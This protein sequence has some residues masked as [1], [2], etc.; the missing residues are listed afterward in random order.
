[1]TMMYQAITTKYLGPSNVRGSRIK[2]RAEAG[3]VTLSYNHRLDSAENH[4]AAAVALCKKFKWCGDYYGRLHG[5]G[6]ADGYVFVF[7][8]GEDAVKVEE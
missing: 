5:G 4:K 2:A 6:T 1:M 3:S 8:N 7:D